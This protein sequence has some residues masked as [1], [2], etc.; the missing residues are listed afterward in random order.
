MK[1]PNIHKLSFP[2]GLIQNKWVLVH[3]NLSYIKLEKKIYK[4]KK[5]Y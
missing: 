5:K 3:Q 2:S 1:N 4:I